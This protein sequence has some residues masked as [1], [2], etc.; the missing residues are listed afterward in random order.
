VSQHPYRLLI[1]ASLMGW[2]F[3]F[4]FWEKPVGANFPIYLSIALI[5]GFILLITNGRKP[6][7]KSL[8]II[9][10][11]AIFGVVTFTRLETLTLFLGYTFSIFSLGV[12]AV[13]YSG[14][15][16]TRYSL[17]DY[18]VKFIYL[19]GSMF[20]RPIAFYSKIRKEQAE[21]GEPKKKLPILPILRG[22][23]IALPVVAFFTALLASADIVFNQRLIEL[24]ELFTKGTITEYF[25]RLFIILYLA[26]MFTGIILHT[27]DKSNDEKLLGEDKPFMKPFLGFTESAI[28]LSSVAILFFLFV[29]IQFR[30]FFGGNINIGIEGYTYSQ[31][32]RRG[33]SELL[34][35]AFS[36]LVMILGLNTI[37]KRENKLQR[38]TYSGLSI[39]IVTLVLI[40]LVSAFQRLSLAIDWHGFSRLRVYPQIFLIWVG[41]LFVTVVVLEVFHRERYFAFAAVLASLG[42]AVSLAV[43]NVDASIVH[44]NVLRSTQGKHFNAPYL[45]SLSLD[46]VP[47]LA[48]E[49]LNRSLSNSVHEGIG[50]A[51]VCHQYSDAF[52]NSTKD[53]WRSFN[54][55]E[56]NAKKA[57]DEVK[58][59]LADYQ[60]N[61]DE[62][63]VRIK[64][65]SGAIFDCLDTNS[66]FGQ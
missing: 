28:I 55:S 23:L 41:I 53:D 52:I 13:T 40:I 12:L 43:F 16:W 22:L 11:F 15:H 49:F 33:F 56:S 1:A 48:E 66:S 50:A 14:S 24:I 61:K 10:P 65:P 42:F 9:L 51:L 7:I 26:Y 59:Q 35:V 8:L 38:N 21:L 62:H 5:I 17:L 3:D 58:G 60:V 18:F 47:A 30:Y 6:A 57:L 2:L 36:S 63:P 37:T 44:H 34:W 32:A 20:Y 31:Y 45:S 39:A 29:V 19:L 25:L 64:T 54:L 27:Y 4:M 46:A